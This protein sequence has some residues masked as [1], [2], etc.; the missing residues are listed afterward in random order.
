MRP[1][2]STGR[3][4]SSPAAPAASAW[5]SRRRSHGAGATRGR[6][7]PRGGPGARRGGARLASGAPASAATS[8]DAAQ[9]DA[10]SSRTWSRRSAR[11]TSWSTTPALTRD[12]ILLRLKDDDWDAVL[13]AN[14]G[15]R[16]TRSARSIK[17]MMKRRVGPDH[18]HH[19]CRRHHRQQGP[20]E[21]RR[22]QGGADRPHQVG[23]QGVRQPQHAGERRRP[24][25]HRDRHDRRLA[26]GGA[27]RLIT[28]RSPSAAGPPGDVAGAVLFLA[29]DLA[30]TSPAR[31][32]WSTAGWCSDAD[33]RSH[34]IHRGT[35]WTTSNE[36]VKDIIVEELGV[37]REKLTRAPASWRISARTASTPSSWSWRSRRSSTSTSPTRTPRSCARSVTR[38]NYLHQ[39]IGK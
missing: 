7:R 1:S 29:S 21:L 23:R 10:R 11:S 14:L 18:Q 28:G 13:D 20:G 16:S 39:K 12:N 35:T 26:G 19:Q 37:E 30:A 34:F 8:A 33:G 6:R 22:Q 31:C 24:R 17:G 3:S 4:R 38:S 5:P 2:T 32:S 9:V 15:A 27:R 25:L 36:K